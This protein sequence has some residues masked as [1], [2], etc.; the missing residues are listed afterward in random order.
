MYFVLMCFCHQIQSADLFLINI[1]IYF[2]NFVFSMNVSFMN[3]MGVY[4]ICKSFYSSGF[5]VHFAQV[6][7]LEW[8]CLSVAVIDNRYSH[9]PS[10]TPSTSGGAYKPHENNTAQK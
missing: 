4:S 3:K 6:L 10:V 9:P 7:F 8:G 5:Y 2:L 1:N